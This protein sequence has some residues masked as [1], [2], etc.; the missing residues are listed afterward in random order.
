ML[1]NTDRIVVQIP[2]LGK[3]YNDGISRRIFSLIAP[4]RRG[5]FSVDPNY[6]KICVSEQHTQEQIDPI[7]KWGTS[8]YV[9]GW[10]G[11]LLGRS[12]HRCKNNVSQCLD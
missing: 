1:P 6:G 11:V 5:T 12:T 4:R 3:K 7:D 9:S 8:P 2:P 10:G